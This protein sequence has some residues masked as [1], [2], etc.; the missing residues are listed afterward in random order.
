MLRSSARI[1]HHGSRLA[2]P[3]AVAA[4]S[5]VLGQG[6]RGRPVVVSTASNHWRM[7]SSQSE[8]KD[9]NKKQTSGDEETS[10]IVLTPG[11]KVVAATRLSMWAGILVFA[12][13]CAYFIGK[14]LMPT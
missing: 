1:L 12:T 5:V 11:Q 8:S 9:S 13:G 3:R 14:E 2:A 7:M 10:E 4:P 6:L